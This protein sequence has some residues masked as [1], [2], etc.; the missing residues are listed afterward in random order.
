MNTYRLQYLWLTGVLVVVFIVGCVA[1]NSNMA[2]QTDQPTSTTTPIPLTATPPKPTPTSTPE[3]Y[4][5]LDP[6]ELYIDM[7]GSMQSLTVNSA[8]EVEAIEGTVTHMMVGNTS[9][10]L[11]SREI[12]LEAGEAFVTTEEYGKIKLVFDSLGRVTIW[13]TPTQKEKLQQLAK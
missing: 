1:A 4:E 8:G 7:T 6:D 11:V 5:P 13:L 3:E 12:V 9:I 2:T 10:A